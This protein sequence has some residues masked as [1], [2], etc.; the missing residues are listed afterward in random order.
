M[1]LDVIVLALASAPRPAGVAALYALLRAAHPRRVLAAYLLGG[2]AFSIAVG[3]LV[4]SIFHGAGLDYRDSEVYSAIEL[5]GGVLALGFAASVATGRRKL[6]PHGDGAEESVVLR[7]LR[8]PSLA[9]AALAGVLTHLP[10]LFYVLALNAIIA[11]HHSLLDEIA[12]VLVFNALWFGA[13]IGF[14][15]IFLLRPGAARTALARANDLGR[16]HSREITAGAFGVAGL[17]LAIK[18]GIGLIG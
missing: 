11:G 14:V 5:A 6:P 18:G 10:G 8:R 13:T 1:S 7:R 12:Q 3:V 16:R 15:V 17:Y 2:L 4:V 9:T